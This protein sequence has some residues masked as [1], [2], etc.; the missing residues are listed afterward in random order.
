MSR[1]QIL[2]DC[3]YTANPVS[4]NESGGTQDRLEL[5]FEVNEYLDL[6]NRTTV[7]SGDSAPMTI[8]D[9]SSGGLYVYFRADRSTADT[10][11]WSVLNTTNCRLRYS[12]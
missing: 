7:F 12:D 2:K 8:A 4:Q 6:K 1:F 3:R 11:D 5:S 9:I 10:A